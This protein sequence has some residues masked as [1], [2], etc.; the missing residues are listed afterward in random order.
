MTSRERI[1]AAL[2]HQQP[3]RV[4]M[5]FGGTAVTGV[6]VSCVAALRDYFGLEKR[7]VKAHEPYQMLGWID[8]DLKEAVG[9]DVNGAFGRET[10]FGFPN[11]DWKPSRLRPP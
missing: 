9:I 3:D 1:L 5:D 4:P 8:D 2:N 10:M 11:E 7:L 6:H